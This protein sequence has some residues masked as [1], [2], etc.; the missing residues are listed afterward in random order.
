MRP[1]IITHQRASLIYDIEN[2][3]YIEGDIM[4]SD[5]QHAK[6]QVFDIAQ[7][8]NIDRVTRVLNLA[9]SECV[10]MFY[11]YT[12]NI[13]GELNIYNCFSYVEDVDNPPEEYH[14]A[15]TPP[16]NF[17]TTT[18]KLLSNLTFEYLV[19]AVIADWMS[20]V[21]PGSKSNWEE[22]LYMI[23]SKIQTSLMSRTKKLRRRQSPF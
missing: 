16:E 22:K 21:N 19:C 17:S 11:P 6:H 20:I 7:D 15:F 2:Y 14:I 18:L 5:N 23:K 12:K 10:E 8:G 9:H 3:S 4:D 1:I 13:I